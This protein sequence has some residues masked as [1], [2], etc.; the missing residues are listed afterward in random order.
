[1]I[2]KNTGLQ[3]HNLCKK[4]WPYNRSLTGNG[5]LRSLQILGKDLKGFKIHKIKSGTN[6]FDWTIPDEW[7]IKDGWIKNKNGKKILNFKKNNLHIMGYSSPIKKK[8]SYQK[9]KNKIFSIPDQPNAI[10][11]MTSYYEKNWGFCMSHNQKKK[12]NKND[13]FD[14]FI[15]SK[16]SKGHLNYGELF[17]K[18]KSSQEILLSSYVCHPS[19]ANNE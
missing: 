19:L 10:P 9:L 11:Y 2:K 5:T 14:I 17:I 6:V 12:L 15:N 16:F 1:M 4:L 18:G 3:I 13:V 8:I 7:N